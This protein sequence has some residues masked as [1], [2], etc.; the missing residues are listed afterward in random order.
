VVSCI[1][2]EITGEWMTGTYGQST[3]QRPG[4]AS[5]GQDSAAR[6]TVW[7]DDLVGDRQVRDRTDDLDGRDG[8]GEGKSGQNES[9]QHRRIIGRES[10]RANRG[11]NE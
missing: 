10:A 3:D 8:P 11:E 5:T 2:K 7:R 1:R 9:R 6:N 4:K